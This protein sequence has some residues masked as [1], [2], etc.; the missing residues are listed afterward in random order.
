MPDDLPV[1]FGAAVSDIGDD[2]VRGGDS[3][4]PDVQGGV[5]VRFHPDDQNLLMN[6]GNYAIKEE[7]P[8]STT[9][10]VARP[11]SRQRSNKSPDDLISLF[12][13]KRQSPQRQKPSPQR[14]R[15]RS[16]NNGGRKTKE[17][18]RDY[19]IA[20]ARPLSH[21]KIEGAELII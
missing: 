11:A 14:S 13:A 17:K 21:T 6:I 19:R 15:S 10:T 1:D 9:Q 2:E 3:P 7:K 16:N 20:G 8:A 4:S 5:G 12:S 18:V